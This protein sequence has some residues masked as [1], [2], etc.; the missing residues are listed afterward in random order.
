MHPFTHPPIHLS[1]SSLLS[2]Y[3][4]INL[5]I[6]PSILLSVHTAIHSSISLSIQLSIY[7]SMCL[8]IFASI[9][10]SIHPINVG[11]INPLYSPILEMLFS[12]CIFLKYKISVIAEREARQII[13]TQCFLAWE[14]VVYVCMY[15]TL[16]RS[17]CTI[18]YMQRTRGL[19]ENT[20]HAQKKTFKRTEEMSHQ[21]LRTSTRLRVPRYRL[22]HQDERYLSF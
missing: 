16:L 20:W 22:A 3:L 11:K 21:E 5:S 10:P 8:S 1:I 6:Y 14:G 2:F 12:S 7:L 17:K 9:H 13:L 18:S 4:S 19:T 15:V